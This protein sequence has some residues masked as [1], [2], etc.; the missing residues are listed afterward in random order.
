MFIKSKVYKCDALLYFDFG[1]NDTA[2]GEIT[3][4]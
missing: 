1:L 2:V 4:V 3:C